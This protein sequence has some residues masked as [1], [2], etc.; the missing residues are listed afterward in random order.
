MRWKRRTPKDEELAVVPPRFDEEEARSARPVVPLAR[1]ADAPSPGLVS[2]NETPPGALARTSKILLAWAVAA[3]LVAGAAV[4]YGAGRGAQPQPSGLPP[5]QGS[6]S[7]ATAPPAP[8]ADANT[9]GAAPADD[10]DRAEKPADGRR[11]GRARKG[12][13]SRGVGRRRVGGARLVG[14]IRG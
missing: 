6:V 13:L 2:T 4:F 5:T 11:H 14:V 8:P 9:S 10:E 1:D 3:T 7:G 12:A